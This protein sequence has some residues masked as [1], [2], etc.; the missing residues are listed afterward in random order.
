VKKL[1][2]SYSVIV[3]TCIWYHCT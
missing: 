3:T 1:L 2:C